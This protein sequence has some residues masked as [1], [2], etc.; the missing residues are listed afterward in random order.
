M[1]CAEQVEIWTYQQYLIWKENLESSSKRKSPKKTQDKS[2]KKK[3]LEDLESDSKKKSLKK[4]QNNSPKKKILEDIE[5]NSPDISIHS[6]DINNTSS[7][8][9]IKFSDDSDII[10][11]KKCKLS[12]IDEYKWLDA[13]KKDD[14]SSNEFVKSEH[15]KEEV[16]YNSDDDQNCDFENDESFDSDNFHDNDYESSKVENENEAKFE[17]EVD[18]K[19]K[20][21]N[22]SEDESSYNNNSVFSPSDEMF[23]S[24]NKSICDK[25]EVD[26]KEKQRIKNRNCYL[27]RKNSLN[28]AGLNLN[29]NPI[30]IKNYEDETVDPEKLKKSIKNRKS[31]LNRKNYLNEKDCSVRKK[32][33]DTEECLCLQCGKII[34]G[35]YNLRI[36]I[37][38]VHE[39]LKNCRLCKEKVEDLHL[40]WKEVHPEIEPDS[41]KCNLCNAQFK[42]IQYL[43]VHIQNQHNEPK[44]NESTLCPICAKKTKC[45]SSHMYEYHPKDEGEY[46]CNDCDKI[47]ISKRKLQKHVINVHSVK[48]KQLC[49][50]CS[51]LG[52]QNHIWT[53]KMN[54]NQDPVKCEVCFKELKN[55][56][57]LRGHMRKVHAPQVIVECQV[58]HQVFDTEYKLYNHT[59]AVHNI[60]E[61]RCEFCGGSYKNRKLL[62]A[63]KR[64]SHA[65]L[66]EAKQ[67][68]KQLEEYNLFSS[69]MSSTN[70]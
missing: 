66:M 57:A 49:P 59:Y 5:L 64:V 11:N 36:H 56:E 8:K 20:E 15:V 35:N 55:K 9:R 23:E 40:H 26:P 50:Y 65:N 6:P 39:K 3:I 69:S 38:T 25:E 17:P 68:E 47:F 63:H 58:C 12:D 32:N 7:V 67:Q 60:Q 30:K 16:E 22:H 10:T 24:V 48:A 29:G 70:N 41:L 14:D 18:V 1:K 51:K 42:K 33:N 62:Q 13:V 37:K 28:S 46:P 2:P 31:Y 45:L 19:V 44:T 34:K 61:S 27:K 4:T 53:C 52:S 21:E 54:Q 43:I